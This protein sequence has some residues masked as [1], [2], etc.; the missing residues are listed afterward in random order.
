MIY[1]IKEE[2]ETN[3]EKFIG[4]LKPEQEINDFIRNEYRIDK[5]LELN[6]FGSHYGNLRVEEI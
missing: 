6:K 3:R 2:T 1:L 4:P 5:I